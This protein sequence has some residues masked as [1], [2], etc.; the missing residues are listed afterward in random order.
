MNADHICERDVLCLWLAGAF[1]REMLL[2]E[3]GT[4]LK[5]LFPGIPTAHA[6]PDLTA[7]RIRFGP[8]LRG[9]D[10]ELH[11]STA[12]WTQHHHADDGAYQNVILHVALRRGR[13]APAP[14]RPYGGGRI[15]ELILESFLNGGAWETV[16]RIRRLSRPD[17]AGGDAERAGAARFARKVRRF[18]MMMAFQDPDT[19]HYV[20]SMK[21]LGF[22]PNK[23]TFAEL[24]R[25]AGRVSS[26]PA[27][28]LDAWERAG[29]SLPWNLQGVRPA[30]HPRR[31][32]KEFAAYVA[33]TPRPFAALCGM[34]RETP[35]DRALVARLAR[36]TG[37][38]G[39]RALQLV[40]NIDLPMAAT[41]PE[42]AQRM[43]RI[44]ATHPPLAWTRPA[45][46]ACGSAEAITS[47]RQQMGLIERHR[48]RVR[49]AV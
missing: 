29:A 31:R 33:R 21:A 14:R 36:R 39:E 38:G 11:L 22:G 10:V 1:R 15:P 40:F 12:G 37:L 25:R 17:P 3:D 49:G 47:V 43:D 46:L 13:G 45:R 19:V 7:A 2:T 4:P 23:A 35:E 16:R 44:E 6:G 30:N 26:D 20:E 18:R 9:G 24:A 48:N 28:Q 8:E 5:I 27:R 42:L 32:M 34:I 41:R